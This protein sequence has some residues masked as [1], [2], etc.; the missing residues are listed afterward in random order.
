MG[1]IAVLVAISSALALAAVGFFVWTVRQG[2]LEH[3][4]RLTFLPLDDATPRGTDTGT[5]S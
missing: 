1:I 4:D 3:S 2:S 5:D